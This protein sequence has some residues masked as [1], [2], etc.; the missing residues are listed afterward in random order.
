MWASSSNSTQLTWVAL[1]PDGLSFVYPK[2]QLG[3]PYFR[4]FQY[5]VRLRQQGTAPPPT[6]HLRFSTR[7]SQGLYYAWSKDYSRGGMWQR[8]DATGMSEFEYGI[9]CI[10]NAR[11]AGGGS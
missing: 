3:R 11:R 1:S 5:N 6:A 4:V 2:Q 7:L 9:A 10:A 8:G